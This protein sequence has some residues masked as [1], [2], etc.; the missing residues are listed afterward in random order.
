MLL[1][2]LGVTILLMQA[3]SQVRAANGVLANSVYLE[4]VTMPVLQSVVKAMETGQPRN[5]RYDGEW[6]GALIYAMFRTGSSVAGDLVLR[7]VLHT[8]DVDTLV[9]MLLYFEDIEDFIYDYTVSRMRHPAFYNEKYG[10][11]LERCSMGH[12]H[13]VA[14]P[15]QRRRHPI[16]PATSRTSS[17]SSLEGGE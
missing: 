12:P 17:G 14:P 4:Y 8:G 11:A 5:P 15:P 9:D 16:P 3:A 6:V 13:E 2:V 10:E 1:V 7:R